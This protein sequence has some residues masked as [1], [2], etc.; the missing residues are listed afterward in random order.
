MKVSII[1]PIYNVEAYIEDCLLS[2]WRQTFQNI[3]VIL[4]ND[5]TKDGSMDVVGKF[6]ENH[7]PRFE[8][9]ICQHEQNRGLSAARNTGIDNSTGDYLYFLD[10]DDEI[11]ADCIE[12]LVRD[13]RDADM[14]VGDYRVVNTDLPFPQLGLSSGTLSDHKL[15]R[16]AFMNARIYQMAWNKLVKKDFILSNNLYFKPGLIHEDCLW[17]FMCG[18][19]IK[20]LSVVK[21]VTYIYK[22]RQNSIMTDIGF[23]KD[24]NA[25]LTILDDMYEYVRKEKLLHDKYVYSYIEEQRFYLLYAYCNK[26]AFT[27]ALRSAFIRNT[28][29]QPYRKINILLWGNQNKRN[30]VRDA[31]YF[32][33]DKAHSEEYLFASPRY[34]WASDNKPFRKTF[35]KWFVKTLLLKLTPLPQPPFRPVLG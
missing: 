11:T 25:Y 30:L 29:A 15:L 2:V 34:V 24:F 19:K 10:S 12:R 6:M 31:H 21:H 32:I 14:V 16:K 9:K 1:I 23:T 5:K 18:C 8:V 17:N 22:V 33:K 26:D 7:P 4:V 35:L 3:E 13:V 20:K 27:P 28:N